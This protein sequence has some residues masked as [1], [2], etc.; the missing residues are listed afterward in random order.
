MNKYIVP[1]VDCYHNL[2]KGFGYV[3]ASELVDVD[4]T[5]VIYF[6][7]DNNDLTIARLEKDEKSFA[8][9]EA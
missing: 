5:L 1:L 3:V 2:T 7:D 6:Y 9:M 8:L 4:G